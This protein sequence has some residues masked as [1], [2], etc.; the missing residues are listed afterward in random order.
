M[1]LLHEALDEINQHS[2]HLVARRKNEFSESIRHPG[3][4]GGL[5]SASA[6]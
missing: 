1:R 3:V 2:L 6:R 4:G 5:K